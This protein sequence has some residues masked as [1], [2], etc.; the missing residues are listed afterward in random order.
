MRS[1]QVNASHFNVYE[2]WR[3]SQTWHEGVNPF[4]E[5][6]VSP[7]RLSQTYCPLTLV[8]VATWIFSG[9]SGLTASSFMAC[10]KLWSYWSWQEN[11]EHWVK[12]CFCRDTL[13]VYVWG[14]REKIF[15]KAQRCR[16]YDSLFSLNL[17]YWKLKLIFLH[18]FSFVALLPLCGIN[19]VTPYRANSSQQPCF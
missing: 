5:S 15:F 18:F 14:Y 4:F 19:T 13:L 16:K 10:L 2:L 6:N 17:S 3:I 12:V 1:R 7:S 9:D 11:R 8:T